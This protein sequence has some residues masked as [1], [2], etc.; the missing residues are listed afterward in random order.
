MLKSALTVA[1]LCCSFMTATV[2]PLAQAYTQDLDKPLTVLSIQQA[3]DAELEAQLDRY[4]NLEFREPETAAALLQSIVSQLND[5]TPIETYVRARTYQILAKLYSRQADAETEAM[6]LLTALQAKADKPITVDAL[7][8]VPEHQFNWERVL[9]VADMAL[10]L[11]KVN[12]R[13]Q[14]NLVTGLNVPFADAEPHLQSDLSGAIR[15]NM[16]QLHTING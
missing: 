13:N 16:I 11:S 10:Y 12:G 15:E 8:G 3:Q 5:S 14:I 6:Q 7:T 9:Q 4:L 1:I 2:S